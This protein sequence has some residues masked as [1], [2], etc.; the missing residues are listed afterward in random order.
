[1]KVIHVHDI[2][3]WWYQAITW[4]NFDFYNLWDP[5]G[6]IQMASQEIYQVEES[7]IHSFFFFERA[8]TLRL[9]ISEFNATAFAAIIKTKRHLICM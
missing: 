5:Q 4:S 1:M 7:L 3:E 9:D 8:N 6:H 2:V